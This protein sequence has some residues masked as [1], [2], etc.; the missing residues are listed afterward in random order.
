MAI[1]QI[2]R[3][4]IRRGL[5][6][7]LP[8]LASAEMGWSVDTQ[9]LYIGNGTIAEGAPSAGITEILT[10]NSLNGFVANLAALASNVASIQSN[11]ANIIVSAQANITAFV[12]NIEANIG[13]LQ[14]NTVVLSASSSGGLAKFGANDVVMSYSLNQGGSTQRTGTLTASRIGTTVYY[15]DDY[16]ETSTTDIVLTVTANSAQGN[17]AY[18]TITPTTISYIL[19]S[20]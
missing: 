9:Q 12:A 14:S 16:V 3:I 7:D 6:Q 19:K 11:V 17:I 5:N 13:A 10:S 1:V 18:T 2:S 15:A 20:Y 8:Q 4:Q